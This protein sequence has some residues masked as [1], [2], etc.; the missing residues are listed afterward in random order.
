[1]RRPLRAGMTLVELLAVVAIIGLLLALLIP[2]VQSARESAR[3]SACANNLKQL[4]LALHQHHE[5]IGALP[6]AANLYRWDTTLV[7][8]GTNWATPNWREQGRTWFVDAMPFLELAQWKN[9]YDTEVAAANARAAASDPLVRVNTALFHAFTASFSQRPRFPIQEC[10]S[11]PSA[12]SRRLE[13]GSVYG[14]WSGT[15]EAAIMSYAPSAG[16]QASNSSNT[17][18]PSP[19]TYCR[20]GAYPDSRAAANPGMF[21]IFN[22]FQCRFASVRDGLGAT[23][24]LCERNGDR[25][26]QS[27]LFGDTQGVI[28]SLRINSLRMTPGVH[29]SYIGAGS[30]HPGGAQ[31]CMADGAVVFLQDDIEYYLYNLLGNRTDKEYAAIP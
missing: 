5:L 7:Q 26:Q 13:D 2:A 23:F 18:C 24:L 28:S 27:A 12:W 19:Q 6:C 9:V 17:D 21:G 8:S 22:T 14:G 1:M 31:F 15:A 3:R 11:N 4:G 20:Q 10:P 16:P 25:A 30:R 29:W